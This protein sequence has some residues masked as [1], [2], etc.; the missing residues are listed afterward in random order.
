MESGGRGRGDV[1]CEHYLR[2]ELFTMSQQVF[3]STQRG[4]AISGGHLAACWEAAAVV[5][6][7]DTIAAVFL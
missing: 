1:N 2:E 6:F 5:A 3:E 7:V 4:L